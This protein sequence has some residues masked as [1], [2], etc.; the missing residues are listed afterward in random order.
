MVKRVSNGRIK[1]RQRENIQGVSKY[2]CSR[3]H[4]NEGNLCIRMSFEAYFSDYS[5]TFSVS[6]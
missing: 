5:S 6:F 4:N 2:V 3:Y 1:E